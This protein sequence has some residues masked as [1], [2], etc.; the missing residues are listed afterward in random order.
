[1]WFVVLALKMTSYMHFAADLLLLSSGQLHSTPSYV[2]A[3]L[4]ID[5]G[6]DSSMKIDTKSEEMLE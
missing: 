4:R 1:M 6:K 5:D 3:N 2:H